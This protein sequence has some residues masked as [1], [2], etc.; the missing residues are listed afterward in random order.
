MKIPVPVP[1]IIK[2]LP[3]LILSLRIN[4]PPPR[5]ARPPKEEIMNTIV[6]TSWIV[7]SLIINV[8][9]DSICFQEERPV[10]PEKNNNKLAKRANMNAN[11][12][13]FLRFIVILLF[14]DKCVFNCFYLLP[15]HRGLMNFDLS[16]RSGQNSGECR[17]EAR[18][19]KPLHIS[20]E[21]K[22]KKIDRAR[23]KAQHLNIISYYS[24]L[25]GVIYG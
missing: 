19:P 1:S 20:I 8:T 18:T 22:G 10:V 23:K 11:A 6:K 13:F 15:K 17:A 9:M 14:Q 21:K 5:T 2:T 3:H 4:T 25:H 12:F 16:M 24:M 7:G